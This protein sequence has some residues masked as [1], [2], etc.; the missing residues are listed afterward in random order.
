MT[1][2]TKNTQRITVQVLS[3]VDG[4]VREVVANVPAA[5]EQEAVD[6]LYAIAKDEKAYRYLGMD[7]VLTPSNPLIPPFKTKYA[8]GTWFARS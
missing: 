7:G 2:T 3:M 6:K 5:N 1:D 4:S 8:E